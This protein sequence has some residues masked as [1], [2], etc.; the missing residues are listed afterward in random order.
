MIKFILLASLFTLDCFA[1]IPT[2]ESLFRHGGNPDVTSNTVALNIK[3]VKEE[4]KEVGKEGEGY[5]FYKI[6]LT[7]SHNDSMKISQIRFDDG[8]YGDASVVQ[9]NYMPNFT[10]FSLKAEPQNLEKG[11]FWG[12]MKSIFFNDGSHLVNFLK[13][14]GIPVKLNAEIINKEKVESLASYKRFL[15]SSGKGG[16]KKELNP[17]RPEDP[18]ERIK[19]EKVLSESMY[20]DLQQVQLVKHVQEIFWGVN[21]ENFQAIINYEKRHPLRLRYKI[22]STEIEITAQDY[23][24][25]D[26]VH[27]SP[28]T[29]YVKT[30]EGARYRIEITSARSFSEREEDISKRLM[31]WDSLLKGKQDHSFKP[32]FLF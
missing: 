18:S 23:W 27:F 3:V 24:L 31:K 13:S 15:I 6:Y 8:A 4:N 16:K 25:A 12:L 9:K 17:L 11:L 14:N 22:D 21:A 28:K 32:E 30:K 10:A 5:S 7:K 2:V 26:G 20:T 1:Y 29:I 19:M